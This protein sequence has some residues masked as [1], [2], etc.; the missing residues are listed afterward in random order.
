MRRHLA[1]GFLLLALATSAGA[2]VHQAAQLEDPLVGG[3]LSMSPQTYDDTH[4]SWRN[5]THE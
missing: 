1:Y 3:A 4:P 2:D 5:T